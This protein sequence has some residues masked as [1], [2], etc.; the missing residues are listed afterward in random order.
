MTAA[1]D[2][3][4]KIAAGRI[5]RGLARHPVEIVDLIG[6]ARD[7]ARARRTLV[8][9]VALAIADEKAPAAAP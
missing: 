3:S 2:G 6:L 7:A 5:A 8:A 1:L 4:G 9:A